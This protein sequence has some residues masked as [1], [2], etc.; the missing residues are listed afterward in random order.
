MKF[1][2]LVI[3]WCFVWMLPLAFTSGAVAADENWQAFL[4]VLT[5]QEQVLIA[6]HAIQEH[7]STAINQLHQRGHASW[8]ETRKQRLE[9]QESAALVAA[10]RNYLESVTRI[11]NSTSSLSNRQLLFGNLQWTDLSVVALDQGSEQPTVAALMQLKD[12]LKKMQG[13]ADRLHLGCSNLSSADPWRK[14]DLL[15][16]NLAKKKANSLA[17]QVKWLE[18]Q[19][20]QPASKRTNQIEFVYETLD[21]ELTD[22]LMSQIEIQEQL[23][24][25]LV[26]LENR[27]LSLLQRLASAGHA[28]EG[29]VDMLASHLE[30]L[31]QRQR[32]QES[33][34][35]IVSKAASRSRYVKQPLKLPLAVI[36]NENDAARQ[37]RDQ[38]ARCEAKYQMQVAHLRRQMLTE[39][40]VRLLKMEIAAGAQGQGGQLADTIDDASALE[41]ANYRWKI[42]LMELE[43]QY[44]AARLKT[45]AAGSGKS[46]VVEGQLP[47][48]ADHLKV[49]RQNIPQHNLFGLKYVALLNQSLVVNLPVAMVFADSVK[50]SAVTHTDLRPLTANLLKFPKTNFQTHDLLFRPVT[51]P[52]TARIGRPKSKSRSRVASSPYS[53]QLLRSRSRASSNSGSFRYYE[54]RHGQHRGNQA[55]TL[56]RAYPF[57]NLDSSLRSFITPAQV[58]WL[59]PGSPNNLRTQQLR[60]NVGRDSY[61]RTG[62]ELLKTRNY[63]DVFGH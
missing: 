26:N 56:T 54:N 7:Q 59:L 21:P 41:I 15:R 1:N 32:Q 62:N 31:N 58:P 17:S 5:A 47:S 20:E 50:G 51:L 48:A 43:M 35:A 16:A 12:G 52:K 49:V 33:A 27:R 34:K 13:E 9:F 14:R 46:I 39:V 29:E 6:D 60:T 25:H 2:C 55:R 23:A 3:S 11:K 42:R 30:Q 61:G 10:F 53:S 28:S 36:D 24:G 57:G 38:F 8:L 37:I 18:L 63:T 45:L 22:A 4:E 19:Q 44:A 40:L